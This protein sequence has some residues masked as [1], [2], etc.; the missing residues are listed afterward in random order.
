[1]SD[2]GIIYLMTTAVKGLVKIGK[3]GVDNFENRMNH[4]EGN[5]Y[6][7]VTSLKRSVAIEVEDYHAKEKLIHILLEKSRV[8]QSELFATDVNVVKQLLLAF[9]GT[10]IYPKQDKE[11]AF[12][13][14]AGAKQDKKKTRS[15][16]GNKNESKNKIK[17]Y[18]RVPGTVKDLIDAGLLEPGAKLVLSQA[19]KT[20]EA[21]VL[22]SG[23]IMFNQVEYSSPSKASTVA[24]GLKANNGWVTWRVESKNG[25]TLGELRELLNTSSE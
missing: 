25:K 16:S 18:T 4:L 24:L 5:G 8:G 6:Y 11:E 19:G 3:T 23:A 2:K 14:A 12:E 9:E 21:V 10:L 17:G 7:N 13:K 20:R 1:M 22:E 15:N